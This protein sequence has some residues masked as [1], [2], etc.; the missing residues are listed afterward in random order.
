MTCRC[1]RTASNSRVAP[2]RTARPCGSATSISRPRRLGGVLT[3]APSTSAA[4]STSTGATAHSSRPRR[5]TSRSTST[6]TATMWLRCS[7]RPRRSSTA[8]GP[9]I[10]AEVQA[11][12]GRRHEA[13]AG[14]SAA[15]ASARCRKAKAFRRGLWCRP[16][17][18]A[19]SLLLVDRA[20]RIDQLC[21][22]AVHRLPSTDEEVW[23]YSRIA[24]LDLDAYH[25]APTDGA[26]GPGSRIRSKPRSPPCRCG[27]RLSSSS[28][29]ASSASR[30]TC[31]ASTSPAAT[32]VRSLAR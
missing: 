26:P 10:L 28:T 17:D 16:S 7:T 21:R 6:C 14:S 4:T 15:G 25:P 31:L 12:Q 18:G 5:P 13:G 22:R 9:Q 27:A 19:D 30:S 8:P 29:G 20:S 2:I 11:E 3:T 23:R 32:I 24:D 1:G